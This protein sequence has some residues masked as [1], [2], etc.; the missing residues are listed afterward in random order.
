MGGGQFN[1][2]RNNDLSRQKKPKESPAGDKSRQLFKP[3]FL[4][5]HFLSS[6]NPTTGS[7]PWSQNFVNLGPINIQVSW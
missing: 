4:N 7:R 6:H 3:E 2:K 1:S 5:Q